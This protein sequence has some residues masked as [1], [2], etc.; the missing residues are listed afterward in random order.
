MTMPSRQRNNRGQTTIFTAIPFADHLTD[1]LA[2]PPGHTANRPFEAMQV[3]P[4]VLF[5]VETDGAI[6][7]ALDDVPGNAGEERRAR[8]GMGDGRG[9]WK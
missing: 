8:R 5:A 4:V 2:R 9:T 6:V 1:L 3:E 7:A